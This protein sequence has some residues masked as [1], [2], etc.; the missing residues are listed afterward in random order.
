MLSEDEKLPGDICTYSSSYEKKERG[1]GSDGKREKFTNE[2]LC[3]NGSIELY[4]KT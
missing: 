1:R 2:Q 4:I 3:T